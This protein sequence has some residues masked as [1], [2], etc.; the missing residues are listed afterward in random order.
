MPTSNLASVTHDVITAYGKT[1]RNVI[2]AYRTGGERM[3]GYFEQRWERA[4]DESS[5]QLSPEVQANARH[6]QKVVGGYYAKGLA[7]TTAGADAAVDQFMKLAAMGVSQAAANASLFEEKTGI[8]ALHKLSAVALPAVTA[9]G[10]L[11]SQIEL[12][13]GELADKIASGESPLSA[14]ARVSPFRKARARKAA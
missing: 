14:A 12:K 9:V 4:L 8:K 3:V 11:A 2:S 13:S 7:L 6:A 5:P 10:K 1:A